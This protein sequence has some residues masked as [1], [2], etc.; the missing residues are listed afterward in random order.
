MDSL[1]PGA[2]LALA[3][4]AAAIVAVVVLWLRHE[5]GP[6]QDPMK[7]M[8]P[9]V[10]V[11]APVARQVVDWGEYSGQFTPVDYV[12]VR[13]RVGGYLTGIHFTDGQMVNKGDLLFVI[14][15]RPYEIA[16][17]SARAKLAQAGSSQNFTQRQLGRAAEL[18]QRDYV[19]QS[20][21]D[22][23]EDESKG[24]SAVVTGARAAVRDAELNLEFTRVTAPVAGRIGAH[25]VGLGNLVT[26]GGNNGSGTLLTTVVSLDPIWFTFDVPESDYQAFQRHIRGKTGPVPAEIRLTGETGWPHQGSIDFVDNQIDRS[27]G[28]IRMRAVLANADGAVTPGTF[29][30]V[31]IATSDPYDALLLPDAAI[32]TDQSRKIV[33]TVA[34]DG[35]VIPKPVVAGPLAGDGLRIVRQGLGPDDKVIING[36]MRARPGAKVTPQPGAIQ[37]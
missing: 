7:M 19:A 32:L 21:L 1:A 18:R 8:A 9:P 33:M 35:T 11:S 3:A 27:S 15:P 2:K 14:D 17:A 25:Q 4:F 30:R 37:P 24:A 23:R 28:T 29:G 6:G 26:A 34:E 12:E 13:A 5:P 16:L 36:I 31:R 22:Q 10:T 20:V